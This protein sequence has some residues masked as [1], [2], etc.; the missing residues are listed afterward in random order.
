MKHRPESF[1]VVMLL[2]IPNKLLLGDL[3]K[4]LGFEGSEDFTLGPFDFLEH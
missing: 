3:Q 1:E 4:S 2:E